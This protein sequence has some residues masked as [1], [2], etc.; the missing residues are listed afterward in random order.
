MNRDVSISFIAL[1]GKLVHWQLMGIWVVG[2]NEYFEVD[3]ISVMEFF[4]VFLLS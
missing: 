4:W 1:A 2:L 3:P